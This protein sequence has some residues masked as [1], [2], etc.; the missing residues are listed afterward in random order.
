MTTKDRWMTEPYS[1]IGRGKAGWHAAGHNVSS[2]GG[3]LDGYLKDARNGALIYDAH[4][5]DTDAFTH[6]VIAGPMVDPDLPPG[7]VRRFGDQDAAARMCGPGGLTGAF[8]T[9]ATLAQDA[10]YSGLDYVACDVYE[11]LLRAV[12]GMKI[13][14]VHNGTVVWR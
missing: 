11:T 13:G 8:K 4:D 12:P 7:G 10:S 9:I 5:A 14:H 3:T 2:S 6:L 1:I